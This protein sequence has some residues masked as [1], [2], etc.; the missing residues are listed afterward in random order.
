MN[1]VTMMSPTP[2]NL[3]ML[4]QYTPQAL[5]RMRATN[6]P[7]G[8]VI[9]L[10][11]RQNRFTFGFTPKAQADLLHV[12]A[13]GLPEDRAVSIVEKLSTYN[14]KQQC[15]FLI[16]DEFEGTHFFVPIDVE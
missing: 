11:D 14:P 8:L 12:M 2:R 7:A 3:D 13:Q 15:L 6:W 4:T 10:V 9:L 5:D 1:A 16:V